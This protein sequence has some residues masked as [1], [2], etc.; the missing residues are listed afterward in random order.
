MG[1]TREESLAKYGTEAYTAWDDPVTTQDA[2]SKGMNIMQ[3]QPNPAQVQGNQTIQSNQGGFKPIK[4]FTN[5]QNQYAEQMAT[6]PDY[7]LLYGQYAKETGLADVKKLVLDIDNTVADI[8]DKI[9]KV[10]PNINKEI[11]N[12]LINE[13]QRGRMV[14][15]EEL[16]LRTQYAD[17]LRS[18]SRLSAEATA[19]AELVN[20]LMG[21]A[22]QSYSQKGDYLKAL[23][24]IE[25][26]NKSGIGIKD[27]LSYIETET[28]IV[29]PQEAVADSIFKKVTLDETG[30]IKT[31]TP[32]K[33]VLD[34]SG[35]LVLGGGIKLNNKP[36]NNSLLYLSGQ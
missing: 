5:L 6:P 22:Q 33:Q 20:T 28:D 18:R 8:E 26:S 17:I 31:E 3:K 21:F 7:Q 32:T 29:D 2:L 9:A 24:D 13:G 15:A 12:Y 27:P 23:M 16:P 30:N 19:K 1:I 11:G 36:K 35:N 34:K 4:G 14:N 10:E 25:K